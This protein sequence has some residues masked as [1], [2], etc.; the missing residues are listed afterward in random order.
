MRRSPSWT[1]SPCR[2]PPALSP[3]A[4]RTGRRGPHAAP[5]SATQPRSHAATQPREHVQSV[6]SVDTGS[7]FLRPRV[8]RHRQMRQGD[9]V[10]EAHRNVAQVGK[11]DHDIG[12]RRS[13]SHGDLHGVVLVE[14]F[15][16]DPADEVAG[17][18]RE[19][20]LGVLAPI[21]KSDLC[22]TSPSH[23]RRL[24]AKPLLV[25]LIYGSGHRCGLGRCDFVEAP[26]A[27]A[28]RAARSATVSGS[29]SRSSAQASSVPSDSSRTSGTR[30]PAWPER[31]C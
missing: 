7:C 15:E 18:R 11:G 6:E 28:A 12:L 13:G 31:R 22:L 19:Y 26:V 27:A 25:D 14:G 30:L 8:W 1:R 2:G 9:R 5:R 23:R 20:P 17:E 4:R 21:L 29:P 16:R 3:A 24:R 10:D